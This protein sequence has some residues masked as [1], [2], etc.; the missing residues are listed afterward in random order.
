MKREAMDEVVEEKGSI[1]GME[2][3]GGE[4]M[5]NMVVVRWLSSQCG[6]A[7]FEGKKAEKAE[8]EDESWMREVQEGAK[9]RR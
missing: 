3:G 9:S 6:I 1:A 4:E 8:M 5:L 7:E 2:V